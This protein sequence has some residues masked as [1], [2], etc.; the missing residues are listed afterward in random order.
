MD[1]IKRTKNTVC[2]QCYLIIKEKSKPKQRT[3]GTS[4]QRPTLAT[5]KLTPQGLDNIT[6]LKGPN[7]ISFSSYQKTTF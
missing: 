6:V 1:L 4:Q 7:S 3:M 2:D 5:Q